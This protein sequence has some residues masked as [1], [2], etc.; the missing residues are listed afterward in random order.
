MEI[1]IVVSLNP[2]FSFI[3]DFFT[4]DSFSPSVTKSRSTRWFDSN[5]FS[6]TDRTVTDRSI[7]KPF[8]AAEVART[9]SREFKKTPIS[10]N[11]NEF[12]RNTIISTVSQEFL[13]KLGRT[14]R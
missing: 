8:A 3:P 4:I 2:L 5:V 9:D 12:R 6:H 14:C 13:P 11:Y 10:I 1:E 7:D